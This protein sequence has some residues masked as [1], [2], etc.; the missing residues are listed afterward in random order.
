MKSLKIIALIAFLA[1]AARAESQLTNI[2]TRGVVGTGD[3]VMIGGFIIGGTEPKTVLIRA[4]GPVLADFGVPGV[5]ANPFLQLFEVNGTLLADNDDWETTT[6]LCQNSGLNCGGAAEITATE[7]E[8]CRPIPLPGQPPTP[9]GCSVE[10]AILV[11]LDPGPYTAIVRGFGGATGVALVEV[12][13]AA[14]EAGPVILFEDSFDGPFP[15][16]NWLPGLGA[17]FEIDPVVGQPA[18]SL[19]LRAKPGFSTNVTN[20]TTAV[21]PFNNVGGVSFFTLLALDDPGTCGA[22]A[23]VG[24][25]I[26]DQG[27]N[28]SRA[29]VSFQC[30]SS[31]GAITILYF[32]APGG[33]PTQL[34]RETLFLDSGF[35]KFAFIIAPDRTGR[36]LR[37]GVEKLTTLPGIQILEA[38][39]L[40]KLSVFR[41]DAA[42]HFDEVLVTRP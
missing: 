32:V 30:S 20:V 16:L 34:I 4:R 36:W 9:T 31:T 1:I 13:E 35:H 21:S 3:D 40:L 15:G 10:S 17:L 25:T 7:L 28:T 33:A 8:P 27:R 37:D 38:D 24:I 2:S 19:L 11:T 41:S 6:A 23:G 26:W 12:F 29:S 39:L 18:P 42:A 22:V 5:L 14:G